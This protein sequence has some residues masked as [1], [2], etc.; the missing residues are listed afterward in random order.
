MSTIALGQ[1]KNA[2]NQPQTPKICINTPKTAMTPENQ[3]QYIFMVSR[4]SV[5]F[6]NCFALSLQ[7]Y[8]KSIIDVLKH[9]KRSI[10]ITHRRDGQEPR[11]VKK[12]R[13][14]YHLT[15]LFNDDIRNVRLAP[16]LGKMAAPARKI[17]ITVPPHPTPPWE[18]ICYP[19]SI[20]GVHNIS[21]DPSP[22]PPQNQYICI[23]FIVHPD[24]YIT[25]QKKII[26]RPKKKKV[27][28]TGGD[29][30]KYSISSDRR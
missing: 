13:S 3:Q 24:D 30:R 26:V 23:G 17:L 7:Q 11:H 12:D 5:S 8:Q 9:D 1:P 28:M 21:T 10:I 27:M 18:R 14:N 29:R 25:I 6:C 2:L 19:A 16:A 22:A 20:F 15:S 4:F